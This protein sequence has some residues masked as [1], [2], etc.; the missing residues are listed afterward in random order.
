MWGHME[1]FL[2]ATKTLCR[3]RR[4]LS[5]LLENRGLE[6]DIQNPKIITLCPN[7]PTSVKTL[8]SQSSVWTGL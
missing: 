8:K 4:S 6:I 5:S 7:H 2:M 3:P 1:V